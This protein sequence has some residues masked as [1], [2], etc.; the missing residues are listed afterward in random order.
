MR[1]YEQNRSSPDKDMLLKISKIFN[2][3]VDYLLSSDIY[4]TTSKGAHH[5]YNDVKLQKNS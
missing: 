3:S 2:V 5:N 1:M 4:N